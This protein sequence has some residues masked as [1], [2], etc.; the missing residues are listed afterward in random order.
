MADKTESHIPNY[1]EYIF[2]LI[3]ITENL[4]IL[5]K[6]E[7]M[8]KF[9]GRC[10]AQYANGQVLSMFDQNTLLGYDATLRLL[11]NSIFE[12][13][14]SDEQ[15]K[16]DNTPSIEQ[17]KAWIKGLQEID[18]YVMLYFLNKRGYLDLKADD[19]LEFIINVLLTLRVV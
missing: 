10:Q 13:V 1:I 5:N 18:L 15:I 12:R 4:V 14:P 19:K 8:F 9:I 17:F 2:N 6:N 7:D 16:L 11:A 3:F